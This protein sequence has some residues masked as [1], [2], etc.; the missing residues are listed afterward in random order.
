MSHERRDHTTLIE[1]LAGN[2][3]FEGWT[4]EAL[5]H[6][7]D[8]TETIVVPGGS[9]LMSEGESGD[10]MYLVRAGR[11]RAYVKDE[12]GLEVAVGEAGPSSMSGEMALLTDEPRSATVR[13]VRDTV[14]VRL[15]R[16]DFLDIVR[17]HPESLLEVTKVLITR[18]RDAQHARRPAAGVETIALLPASADVDLPGFALQLGLAI[19]EAGQTVERVD[20]RRVDQE[21]GPGACD[22]ELDSPDYATVSRWLAGFE[23]PR[24]LVLYL[25]DPQPNR[26]SQRCARQADVIVVVANASGVPEPGHLELSIRVAQPDTRFELVLIHGPLV[27]RPSNTASWLAGR[28]VIRHHHVRNGDGAHYSR[29]ARLLSGRAIGL[30]FSGGGARAFA[31]IGIIRALQEHGIPIDVAGGASSGAMTACGV[32]LEL[33]A[34]E[35]VLHAKRAYRKLVDYTMPLVAIASGAGVDEGQRFVLGADTRIEDFWL[36]YF[37]VATDMSSGSLRIF[38]RGPAWWA[39]RASV[40]IPGI[41]PPVADGEGHALIDGGLL[42]NLPVDVMASRMAGFTIASD[43]R[44]PNGPLAGELSERGVVSGWAVATRRLL[45]FVPSTNVPGIAETIVRSIEI[46]SSQLS[47]NADYTFRPPVEGYGALNVSAADELVD[48]GYRY[49]LQRLEEDPLTIW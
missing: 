17:H 43:L 16:A 33:Q 24:S 31:H 44:S 26:W 45:P 28:D 49:A 46:A 41:F 39:V 3:L 8:R 32:A 29:V 47:H 23:G 30:V 35:I 48:V 42:D 25:M 9:V 40:S 21:F 36:N 37:C 12:S 2:P 18:L 6:L 22:A 15:T 13:A 10:A 7:A 34:D 1:F 14:V 38:D 27:D 4:D 19:E 5:S 20:Q 11:L